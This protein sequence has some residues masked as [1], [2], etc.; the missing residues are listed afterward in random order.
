MFEQAQVLMLGRAFDH[1]HDLNCKIDGFVLK[2]ALSLGSTVSTRASLVRLCA[3]PSRVWF[4][5]LNNL[6]Q[7]FVE[8]K[9]HCVFISFFILVRCSKAFVVFDIPCEPRSAWGSAFVGARC[10]IGSVAV[11]FSWLGMTRGLLQGAEFVYQLL[12][13]AGIGR[14][15]P[16]RNQK[17]SREFT[18]GWKKYEMR[19]NSFI[20]QQSHI[21]LNRQC[22]L[23]I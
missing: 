19:L 6:K 15:S 12:S 18:N 22:N 2:H 5:L 4:Q 20:H 7:I 3:I 21:M 9:R 23:L 13:Q 1:E 16:W 10:G 14:T 11:L 8:A 17:S